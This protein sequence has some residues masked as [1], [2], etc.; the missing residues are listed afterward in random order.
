MKKFHDRIDS[1]GRQDMFESFL[2]EQ[3]RLLVVLGRAASKDVSIWII[4][5]RL[6]EYGSLQS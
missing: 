6:F 4:R 1:L 3:I 5:I 2:K